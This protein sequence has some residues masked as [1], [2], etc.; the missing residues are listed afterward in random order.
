LQ[1]HL[2]Q[3]N[4][5]SQESVPEQEVSQQ[6]VASQK[7][8]KGDDLIDFG[9]DETTAPMKPAEHFPADLKAAQTAQGGKEQ[10]AL[11]NEL[12]ATATSNATSSSLAAAKDVPAGGALLDFHEDLAMAVPKI[13]REDTDTKSV[14]E[15][16]DARG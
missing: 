11:E 14:D 3:Q 12:A 15:F 10:V 7:S 5:A 4:E 9:E 8:D 6:A 13:I 16:V 1:A 2:P